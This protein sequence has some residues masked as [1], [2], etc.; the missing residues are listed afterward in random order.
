MGE[1]S[2]E[3][4]V[5]EGLTLTEEEVNKITKQVQSTLVE[6]IAGEEAVLLTKVVVVPK[7]ETIKPRVQTIAQVA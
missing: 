2:L 7:V 3:I 6:K 4:Q 1:K 5:P